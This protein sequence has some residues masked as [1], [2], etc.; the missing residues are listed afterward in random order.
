MLALEVKEKKFTG[1]YMID[2]SIPQ[3][4]HGQNFR[5]TEWIDEGSYPGMNE[6]S[7]LEGDGWEFFGDNGKAKAQHLSCFNFSKYIGNNKLGAH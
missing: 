2:H 3:S 1:G 5:Q 7:H 4:P 6:Y